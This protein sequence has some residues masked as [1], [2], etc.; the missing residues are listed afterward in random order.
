MIQ[1]KEVTTP[2]EQ[3]AF[4]EFPLKLYKNNPDFV[5]PLYADEM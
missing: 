4:V 3:R 2:K 1:V 5:P